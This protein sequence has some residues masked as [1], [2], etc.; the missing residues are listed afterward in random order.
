[1]GL[2]RQDYEEKLVNPDLKKSQ[3]RKSTQQSAECH[4]CHLLL[5]KMTFC[6]IH[7]L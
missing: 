2:K 4:F 3:T 1:M 6:F 7:I 5:A